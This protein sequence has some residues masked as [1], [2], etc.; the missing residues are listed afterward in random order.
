MKASGC[1]ARMAYVTAQLGHRPPAT[2]LQATELGVGAERDWG[3]CAM[4]NGL[5][6]RQVP[7]ITHQG[8]KTGPLQG[9]LPD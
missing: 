4:E 7:K 1:S 6:V 2:E 5:Q 8:I 3:Q 9:L